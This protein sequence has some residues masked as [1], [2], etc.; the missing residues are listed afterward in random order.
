MRSWRLQRE[1]RQRVGELAAGSGLARKR[2]V[3][4]SAAEQ[5]DDAQQARVFALRELEEVAV[6]DP[7]DEP[8]EPTK[9][10]DEQ[11]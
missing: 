7:A 6:V 11:G 2:G 8:A 9:T 4:S 10:Q 5:Q 3:E 1:A